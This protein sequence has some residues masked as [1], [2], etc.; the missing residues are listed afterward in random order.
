TR[1]PLAIHLDLA[2]DR[3]HVGAP[4]FR[5]RMRDRIR[6]VEERGVE[7]RILVDRDRTLPAIGRGDEAKLPALGLGLEALLLV[8]R[9][10]AAAR[11]LDPDL[12]EMHRIPVGS[13][14]LAVRDARARAHALDV[15]GPDDR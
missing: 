12:Q 14:E 4:A 1:E 6:A 8:A 15:A 2:A 10:D 13:V 9:R 7:A 3:V 11:G 5:E